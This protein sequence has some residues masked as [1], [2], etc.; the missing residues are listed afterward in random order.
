MVKANNLHDEDVVMGG[1]SKASSFLFRKRSK[2]QS[3][4]DAKVPSPLSSGKVVS[5]SNAILFSRECSRAPKYN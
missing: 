4:E 3:D 1:R 2:S 5:F